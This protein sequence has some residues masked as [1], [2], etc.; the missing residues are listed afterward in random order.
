MLYVM[1]NKKLYHGGLKKNAPKKLISLI[2]SSSS[3][4]FL[5]LHP[6]WTLQSSLKAKMI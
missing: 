4:T 3:D 6:L 2:F 1:L 5:R